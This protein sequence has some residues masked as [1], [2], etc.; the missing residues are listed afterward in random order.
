M[1]AAGGRVLW[2]DEGGIWSSPAAGGDAV[3]LAPPSLLRG[4]ATDGSAAYWAASTASDSQSAY[5]DI[6]SAPLSGGQPRK[7]GCQIFGIDEFWFFADP[8][9]VYYRS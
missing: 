8:N 9:A 6:F 2:I 1:C 3:R 5:A 4:L 7:V